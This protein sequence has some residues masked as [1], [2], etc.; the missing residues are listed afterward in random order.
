MARLVR[1]SIPG[2][3][4]ADQA[5]WLLH[6]RVVLT[7]AV[8]CELLGCGDD[9]FVGRRPRAAL[10]LLR[11]W[12][13]E[14]YAANVE[15]HPNDGL[16]VMVIPP[17][18]SEVMAEL[19]AG[20]EVCEAYAMLQTADT[21]RELADD[22]ARVRRALTRWQELVGAAETFPEGYPHA[23]VE[24]TKRFPDG[25]LE[26]WHVTR[27]MGGWQVLWGSDVHFAHGPTARTLP[28]ILD[29]VEQLR[30][31]RRGVISEYRTGTA[32]Q[33]LTLAQ[34]LAG[35]AREGAEDPADWS[36]ELAADQEEETM[37]AAATS[38]LPWVHRWASINDQPMSML[39][40][41]GRSLIVPRAAGRHELD[42][43]VA[44]MRE[45]REPIYP[46]V[47][48]SAEELPAMGEGGDSVS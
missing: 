26:R 6:E 9:Q 11:R 39:W 21:R 14:R 37:Q 3:V 23:I 27:S 25:S 32:A 35:D 15:T 13:G 18:A 43:V 36:P 29:E 46:N 4:E 31:L 20:V 8:C 42:D 7:S 30:V 45:D 44:A 1:S 17:G 48:A 10:D 33:A 19:R 41:G 16:E 22:A 5:W 34:A 47:W 24:L 40:V 38:R 2:A 12:V 28:E